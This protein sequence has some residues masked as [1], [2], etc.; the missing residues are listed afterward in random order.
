MS[1]TFFSLCESFRLKW[2]FVKSIPGRR[3]V[4]AAGPAWA[5]AA[6]GVAVCSEPFAAVEVRHHSRN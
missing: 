6:A 5:A 4:S 2:S 3:P 1:E